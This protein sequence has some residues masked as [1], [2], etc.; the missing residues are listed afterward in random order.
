MANS[1]NELFGLGSHSEDAS[2]VAHLK[3]QETTGTT[4]VDSSSN[5]NDGTITGMGPD[6]S[7]ASGPNNWLPS[8]YDFDGGKAWGHSTLA[9]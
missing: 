2:L 1:Y 8:A 4:A 5:S 3:L 7:F 9:G 6:P